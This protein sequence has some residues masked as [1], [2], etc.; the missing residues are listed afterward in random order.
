MQISLRLLTTAVLCILAA[1]AISSPLR[2]DPDLV[3]EAPP[4]F[5]IDSTLCGT[6][7]VRF[8]SA[9]TVYF[10]GSIVA[11]CLAPEGWSYNTIP[12]NGSWYRD[13]D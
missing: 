10:P 9:A 2:A 8:C 11:V 4:C 6:R 1:S 7:R 12:M 3:E 5:D 13:A